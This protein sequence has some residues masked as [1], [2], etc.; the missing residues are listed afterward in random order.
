VKPNQISRLES[1]LRL[2]EME[3]MLRLCRELG[4]PVGYVLGGEGQ[5]PVADFAETDRRKRRTDPDR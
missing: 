1:G 5:L 4:A 3:T 2:L